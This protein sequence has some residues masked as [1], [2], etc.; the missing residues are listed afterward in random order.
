MKKVL[1][2]SVLLV[3]FTLN[4][5]AGFSK[6][7]TIK[8]TLVQNANERFWCPVCG[9]N[10]KMFYKTSYIAKLQNSRDRQYC[11][12]RCLVV[13]MQEY[14]ID[15]KSIKVVDAHTQK[16]IDA[17]SAYFV[18]GSRVKGTMSKISKLAFASKVDAQNFMKKYGG[19][20][21]DFDFALKSAKESLSSDI[22]M[23]KNKK[24]K[25]IYPMGKKIYNKLCSKDIE[26]SD[27]L[28]INELK[29]DLKL[30]KLCKSMKEKQLQAVALY[31]W[32][33]KRFGDLDSIKGTIKVTKDEKCPICGMFV[34]KYPRWA[35]Q[36]FYGEKHLSFDGVKDMMKY[37]FEHKDAISKI[38]VTDYYSQKAIDAQDAYFVIGSDVYGPMGDEL[39]PFKKLDDAKVFMLDHKAKEILK[40]KDITSDAVYKLDE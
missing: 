11:S 36:L 23:I 2:L 18:I 5:H 20:I 12:L 17:S 26:L 25:K 1:F 31:L 40:F 30:N 15:K 7:A 27:Y 24:T 34:Y 39:I 8:P 10:L 16:I 29:A 6:V 32:E 22:A 14:G 21:V 28:E 19:E 38:L 37:Y 33:V 9:M 3:F 35:A 4:L 13:D